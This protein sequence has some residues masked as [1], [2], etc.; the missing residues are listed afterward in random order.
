MGAALVALPMSFQAASNWLPVQLWLHRG[1]FGRLDP[2]LGYD[3]GFYI[4]TLP[5]IDDMASWLLVLLAL[6]AAAS[7]AIYILGGRLGVTPRAGLFAAP[8]PRQHLAI[9]AAVAFLVIAF[10]TWFT[11]ARELLSPSGLIFG[12]SYTDVAVRIPAARVQF[13]VALLC[14]ALALVAARRSLGP[15]VAAIALYVLTAIGAGV[16]AG[17][18]QRFVVSPNEQ[19]RETPYMT[20]NIAATQQAF[21]LDHVEERE[22]SGDATLSFSD[23]AKNADTLT[24][25]RLWDHQPLLDTFGQLQ[26]IR[27]YYDFS[28][29]DNDRYIING[30]YRQVMLSARELNSQALSNRTWINEHLTFTHGYGLTLGPVNQVT[31]EGL[32]VLFVKDLPPVSTADLVVTEPRIYFGELSNDYVFVGTNAPEFDYPR[33]DDNVTSHYQGRR[34]RRRGLLLAEAALRIALPIAAGAL[35]QRPRAGT[36][37]LYHRRIDERLER[38]APFLHYEGDPYHRGVRR[39]AVLDGGC[40]YDLRQISVLDAGR[41]RAELHPQLRSRSWWTPT[42]A[43][44]RSTWRTRPIQ[45]RRRSRA[46]SRGFSSRSTPCPPAC[47]RTSATRTGCSRCRRRCSPR[48]T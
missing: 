8:G 24:N 40:L 36:R 41:G 28:S 31:G 5:L 22:L 46:S 33:G 14:A 47:A 44:R 2:V 23:I 9:L 18:V 45:S 10:D 37:V 38:I 25:V 1:T 13:A 3:I 35:Q 20:Y 15:M 17:A 39:A 34:R 43:R 30:D 27:P 32:P 12:A 11:P 6:S 4:F 16:I 48:T 19:A 7:I 26:E 42:T 21:G 29:V